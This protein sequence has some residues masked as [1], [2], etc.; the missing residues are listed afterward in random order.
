MAEVVLENTRGLGLLF[1]HQGG[2]CAALDEK[3]FYVDHSGVVK[4]SMALV[5]K[6]LHEKQKQKQTK[7]PNRTVSALV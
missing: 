2:L 3:C 7:T 1:L 5:K 6:K 4:D